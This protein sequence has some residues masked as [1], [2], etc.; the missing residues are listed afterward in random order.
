MSAQLLTSTPEGYIEWLKE[1]KERIRSAQQRA[2]LAANTEMT[3]L[4]WHIGRDILARQ[5]QQGWGAKVVERLAADLRREFPDMKGFSSRNLKYMRLF[6]ETWS[7]EQFVQR[8]VA[9]IPWGHNLEILTKLKISEEREWY[10]R[11]D[12]EYGWSRPVLVHQIESRLYHRQGKAIT[13]FDKQLPAS[14]SDLA[15]QTLKDI[16]KP[17]GISEYRLIESIPEDLQGSLPSIEQIEA[18]LSSNDD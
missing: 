17:V 4:Y 3:V 15:Q 2:V 14:L 8:V 6:A 5:G 16:S 10:A 12:I 7:N 1:I 18:E 13:N 9:Q 11:A